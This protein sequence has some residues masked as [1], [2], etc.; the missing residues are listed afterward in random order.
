MPQA[1]SHWRLG[2]HLEKGIPV[3]LVVLIMSQTFMGVWYARGRVAVDDDHEKRLA[4]LEEERRA[5][6]FAAR[7]AVIEAAIIEIRRSNE[8]TEALLQ[9]ALKVERR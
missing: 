9:Q 1:V 6:N 7:M 4:I 2:W 5:T 3:A 8:R